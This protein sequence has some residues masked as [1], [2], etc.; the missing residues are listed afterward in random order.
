MEKKGIAFIQVKL[1]NYKQ[2]LACCIS[3]GKIRV[4]LKYVC[5]KF[6]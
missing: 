4:T 1:Y 5:V 6:M 3:D 2:K